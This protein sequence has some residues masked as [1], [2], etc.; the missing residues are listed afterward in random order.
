[1]RWARSQG[2]RFFNW[3]GSPPGSGVYRYKKGWGSE[4]Y[5]Y[6]YLTRVTGDVALEEGA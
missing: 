2:F 6:S 5:A 3:Q 1:M 4:D